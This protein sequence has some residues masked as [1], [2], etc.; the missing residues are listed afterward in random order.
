MGAKLWKCTAD[1]Q[2]ED[3]CVGKI[4]TASEWKEKFL[5]CV[6]DYD[7]DMYQGLVD[8][9]ESFKT[10]NELIDFIHKSLEITLE[11]SNKEV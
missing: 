7:H 6:E 2:G 3:F 11:E 10:D 4:M 8:T 9:L 1:L 5:D